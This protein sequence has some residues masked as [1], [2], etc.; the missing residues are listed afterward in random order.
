VEHRLGELTL[1]WIRATGLATIALFAATVALW[2]ST[3]GTLKH[4]QREFDATHRP[5]LIVR[6]VSLEPVARR[7]PGDPDNVRQ[8]GH[9][10]HYQVVNVGDTRATITHSSTVERFLVKPQAWTP[11]NDLYEP[12]LTEAITL[13]S[14]E[15][16]I[17]KADADLLYQSLDAPALRQQ[18]AFFLG[19][20]EYID[21]AN[22]KRRTS[23]LRVFNPQSDQFYAP[24]NKEYDYA[25]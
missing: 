2:W 4:L 15:T 1:W 20:I 21:P 17:V 5:R 10:I 7:R 12:N 16:W 19:Y 6:S 24:E 13:D 14:G 25:D 11:G 3:R 22:V 23:F 18:S 9:D 8:L